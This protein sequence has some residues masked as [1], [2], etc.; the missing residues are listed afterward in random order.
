MNRD[1][2]QIQH[3]TKSPLKSGRTLFVKRDRRK[4]EIFLENHFLAINKK[5]GINN[6]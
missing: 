1:F 6:V 2:N 4:F 3:T 5:S